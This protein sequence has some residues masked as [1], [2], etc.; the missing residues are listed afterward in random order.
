MKQLF[1]QYGIGAYR[2]E[3]FVELH[4]TP[5]EGQNLADIEW[6]YGQGR[7]AYNVEAPVD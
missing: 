3:N 4:K 6:Q 5:I 2:E 7:P 1:F